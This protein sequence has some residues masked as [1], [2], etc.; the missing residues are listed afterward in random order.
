MPKAQVI[1]ELGAPSVM[2]WQEW[3]VHAV[4][5]AK[6]RPLRLE[7]SGGQL[8]N[9]Q[10]MDAFLGWKIPLR[11]SLQTRLMAAPKSGSRLPTKGRWQS[12]S[13]RTMPAHRSLT[14]KISIPCE[15]SS[16]GFSAR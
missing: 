8:H 1:H 6:G 13:Q 4:V 10:M 14:T 9:S 7:I 5:D 2:Q 3:E 11:P 15:T 16:N 12:S